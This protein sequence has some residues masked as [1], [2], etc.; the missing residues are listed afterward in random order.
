MNPKRYGKGLT[1]VLVGALT[2]AL[3]CG[4]EP[5][6]VARSDQ[7]V[8]GAERLRACGTLTPG[9]REVDAVE[10]EV[11][12]RLGVSNATKARR[13]EP[14]SFATVDVWFHVITAS[15]GKE[16]DVTRRL[17]EQMEQL[18]LAYSGGEDPAAVE[19]GLRFRLVGQDVTANDTWFRNC[20]AYE[21]EMK[22]ALYLASP[23]WAQRPSVL[24]VYTCDA[25]G[26]LGWAYLPWSVVG[27]VYQYYDGVVLHYRSLPGE[28]SSTGA[29]T[30]R[31]DHQLQRRR[32]R[33]ARDRPLAGS[34]AH[35]PGRLQRQGRLRG[36]HGVGE[37][38]G[39][40][41]QAA[42]HLPGHAAP[43]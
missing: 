34:A 26:L 39:V 40:L 2:G 28:A 36:G 22:H 31:R 21:G 10:R 30:S 3:G 8:G 14:G 41:L 20:D 1:V 9:E 37:D 27:T 32:Q 12:Q 38:P 24:H 29:R 35:L 4:G 13:W 6:E 15:D 7:E 33:H 16:G 42:R 23:A 25:G 5:G 17:R 11:D 18:N 19:T 43:R